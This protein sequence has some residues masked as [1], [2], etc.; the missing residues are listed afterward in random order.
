MSGTLE[1][2]KKRNI[3]KF[4]V[5][6][7]REPKSV[8]AIA[9]SSR[10]LARH[11]VECVDWTDVNT[12]LEYGPG[13]GIFTEFIVDTMPTDADFVSIELNE[14]FADMV[15]HRFPGIN[16]CNDSVENVR[17]IC[18]EYD[19]ETVDAIVSG[20]PWAIFSDDLQDSI[21]DAMMTVLE[22]GSQFVTFGYLQGLVLP[23]AQRFKKKLKNY[24]SEVKL[25]RPVWRNFP[26]A[27]IYQCRK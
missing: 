2:P 13:T 27:V 16:V 1:K 25:T 3:G 7:I 23:A 11:M 22:P 15:R 8:G 19:M 21:L 20:L 26:P 5:Q 10:R 24:F 12:V 9:P 4:L 18:D 14:R 17:K 6:F